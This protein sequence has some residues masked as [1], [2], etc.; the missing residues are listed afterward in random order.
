MRKVI[1]PFGESLDD[2]EIF[3]RLAALMGVEYGFT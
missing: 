1:K 3:R 2:F